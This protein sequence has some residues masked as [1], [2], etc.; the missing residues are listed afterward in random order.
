M[1]ERTIPRNIDANLPETAGS[2][3]EQSPCTSAGPATLRQ[4]P[5]GRAYEGLSRAVA[6]QVSARSSTVLS[7]LVGRSVRCPR[8]SAADAYLDTSTRP[9]TRSKAMSAGAVLDHVSA[10][11]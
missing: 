9:A 7:T 10:E 11:R 3:S 8:R 4:S 2:G 5:T 6:R 1:N